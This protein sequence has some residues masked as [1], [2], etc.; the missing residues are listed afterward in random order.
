MADQNGSHRRSTER[1]RGLVA[2]TFDALPA[3]IAVVDADGVIRETNRAWRQFGAENGVRG[4]RDMVGENYLAVCDGSDDESA[5]GAAAGIRSVLAGERTEF[6]LEYPC[7]SPDKRRWFLM[8]VIAL[9]EY[10]D[11]HA[12][13]MHIDITDRKEVELRVSAN[14]ETL[15]TVASVLSHDLRNPLNVAMGRAEYLATDP[16]VGPEVVAEQT[17]SIRSSLDRMNAIVDDALVLASGSEQIDT[18]HVS[19]GALARD[20]WSHVETGGATLDVSADGTLVADPGL[21]EQ[22]LENLFRNAIDHAEG[23]E[24][25]AVGTTDSGFYVA[26]DGPGITPEDRERVFET[27]YSTGEADGNT[28]MGLAIVRKIADAHGWDVAL[29]DAR[30]RTDTDR[31]GARFEFEGVTRR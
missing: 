31:P 16:A 25:I 23:V 20:A 24:T 7:H 2:A 21:L 28:G 3:Q 10:D 6:S 22:L 4:E 30:D 1:E 29:T 27:G 14:N 19:L 12:L 15:S 18:E 9:S 26:D 13:V 5:T 8:R 11:P 17:E